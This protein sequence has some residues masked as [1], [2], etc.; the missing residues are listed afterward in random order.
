MKKAITIRNLGK[1]YRLGA[2]TNANIFLFD[3][4][5]RNMAQRLVGRYQP[6][7]KE[8]FWAL[9][10]FNLDVEQ[11]E[12]LGVIGRNGAGKST[13]L[14]ILSRITKMTTGK[15][16]L[17]GRTGSLLE[18]GVGF[19]RELT[20]RENI[21]LNG[22]ILGMTRAE[23]QRQYDAIV[24]FSGIEQ[25]LDTPVKRYS[26]GML[27]RLGFAVAAHLSADIL[28]VDEVLAV[29]DAAFQRKSLSKM[30]DVVNDGRTVLF[31]SHNMAAV[32]SLCT[33]AIVLHEGKM[34]YDGAIDQAIN[35]YLNAGNLLD[36]D[37][38][39]P[40]DAYRV[41]TSSEIRLH[42]VNLFRLS[43]EQTRGFFLGEPFIIEL[44]FEALC[45]IP[46]LVVEL[47]ISS[48]DG[49]RALTTFNTETQTQPYHLKPGIN[50]IRL[51]YHTQLLPREYFI[52]IATHHY[53]SG[54]TMEWIE[55]TLQFKIESAAYADV[56]GYEWQN[57][58]FTYVRGYARP[59]VIWA[60]KSVT[61]ELSYES[62]S[63]S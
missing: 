34:A 52:D 37:G 26:S 20:G 49:I 47:G 33:R 54:I 45:E 21:F 44:T 14:K 38:V 17:Y 42:R 12:I 2:N 29:G 24:D 22:M 51:E 50:T 53:H 56:R 28:I 40:E 41:H 19:H 18:V 58:A 27:V 32:K 46:D 62:P 7:Q 16:Q 63:N 23:V 57:R 6:E 5:L 3:K 1:R 13:L 36:R 61:Q 8:S 31:V 30:G 9:R 55:Q 48:S 4:L 60:D 15:I 35:T 39:I 10:D 25:F 43:G 59:Q 11:G